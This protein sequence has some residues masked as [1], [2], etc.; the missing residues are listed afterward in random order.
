M[1]LIEL[2]WQTI[3]LVRLPLGDHDNILLTSEIILILLMG[4]DGAPSGPVLTVGKHAVNYI[5]LPG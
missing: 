3:G 1:I 4:R 2:I 5:R